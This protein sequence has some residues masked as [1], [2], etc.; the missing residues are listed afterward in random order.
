MFEA[1]YRKYIDSN[2][3]ITHNRS[4][5]LRILQLASLPFM[6]TV[7]II[8]SIGT[9]AMLLNITLTHTGK[10]VCNVS[11]ANSIEVVNWENTKEAYVRAGVPTVVRFSTP[12]SV[13]NGQ[14]LYCIGTSLQQGVNETKYYSSKLFYIEGNCYCW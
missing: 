6:M 5:T 8:K 11:P 4:H 1:I 3:I 2:T 14:Y 12:L 9:T 7:D 10:V 13:Q